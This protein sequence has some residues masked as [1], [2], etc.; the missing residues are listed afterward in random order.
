MSRVKDMT[1]GN[2]TR[3]ILNFSLPLILANLGQQLYMIADAAI[4]GRG[5]G[6]KALA[7]VGATDWSYWVI[8]WTITTMTQGFATF[9]A[10]YFGERDFGKM[11]KAIAMSCLLSAGMAVVLTAAGLALTRPVL[12]WLKTPA[13]ILE[14]SVVYLSTMIAGSLVV[15]GYNMTASILRAFGDGKSPLIAMVIAAVLNVGLDLVTVFLLKWG[16]FGAAVASVTAQLVA[17]GYCFLRIVKVEY[18][19]LDKAAFRLDGQMIRELLAFG[20]PLAL[21]YMVIN[22]SGMFLQSTVNLQGS[23]FVAGYTANNKVYGLLECSAISL[24]FAA[25]TFFSQNYGAKL[26]DRFRAGMRATI[27]IGIGMALVVG[28]L[29]ALFGRQILSLFIDSAEV[30]SGQALAISHRYL[31]TMSASLIILFLIYAYRSAL[32]SVGS[33]IPSMISGFAEC[34]ARILVAKGLYLWLGQKVLYFSEPAAWLG[35]LVFI[36]GAYY[37]LRNRYLI[38]AKTRP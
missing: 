36:M 22:A 29:M 18:V 34:G 38:P 5:L 35:S 6:V 32:Q 7:A 9:V 20:L 25:T 30:G 1:A 28:G 19:K 13:D 10:R 37:V 8:L 23:I 26:L 12:E 24:G 14:Q 3:L 4:V 21:Q 16:V 27:A 33:S 17:F 31:M 2:P 15:A 11:N